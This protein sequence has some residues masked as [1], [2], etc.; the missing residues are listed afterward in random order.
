[1]GDAG[2]ATTVNGHGPAAQTNG[3]EIN[4]NVKAGLAKM[5]KGGVIMDVIN[6]EQVSLAFHQCEPTSQ[7]PGSYC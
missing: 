7:T 2:N 6:P 5:L 1:M 4:F 3:E